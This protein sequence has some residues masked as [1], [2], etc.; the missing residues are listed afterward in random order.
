MT[1]AFHTFHLTKSEELRRDIVLGVSRSGFFPAR[2]TLDLDCSGDG[3][4]VSASLANNSVLPASAERLAE[5]LAE[6]TRVVMERGGG[7]P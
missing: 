4:R 3:W 1:V 7:Q 6:V 2:A 5:V